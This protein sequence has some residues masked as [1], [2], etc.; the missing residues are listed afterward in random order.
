MHALTIDPLRN[1]GDCEFGICKV[2]SFLPEEDQPECATEE[3][4]ER[5]V[6]NR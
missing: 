1:I 5:R 2:F 6:N 4:Q 3:T